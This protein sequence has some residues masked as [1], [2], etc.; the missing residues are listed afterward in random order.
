MDLISVGALKT[1]GLEVSIRDGVLKTTKCS[2]VVLKGVRRNNLYYLKGSTVT[3]QVATSTDSDDDSTRLWY[4]RL[5]YTGE[6]F[7]QALA[8]QDLLK[9]TRTYK[10]EFCEHCIIRKKT[11]VK[12][13]TTTQCT[14][15]ILD[16][17]HTNIW[18]P[19]KM[20]F[21]GG[22]Y[23]F[24]TFIDDYSKRCW[25]YTMKHKEKVLQLFVEWKNNMEKSTERKI[26][27]LR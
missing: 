13:G 14:K 3:D 8:K 11:K 7:L 17:V 6:K 9:S 22:N 21:I 10:L 24:V 15:G 1:L 18:G 26:K 4:M 5:G 19:T 27:V 2:M 16:Y 25:V 20:T 23:Y 12:F